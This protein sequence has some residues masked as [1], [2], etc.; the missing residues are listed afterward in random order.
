[1]WSRFLRGA[2]RRRAP[3]PEHSTHA[4][5][6]GRRHAQASRSDKASRS[7]TQRLDGCRATPHR[8]VRLDQW[9]SHPSSSR[10]RAHFIADCPPVG[11]WDLERGRC[12]STGATDRR[13]GHR[14]RDGPLVR[15]RPTMDCRNTF[16]DAGGDSRIRARTQRPLPAGIPRPLCRRRSQR[17]DDGDRRIR[18]QSLSVRPGTIRSLCGPRRPSLSA[19]PLSCL[20]P[21]RVD[22][23]GSRS[24]LLR[25][26]SRI[27]Y[28]SGR[29]QPRGCGL[30]CRLEVLAVAVR[31][32][33]VV[34]PYR[35][36]QLALPR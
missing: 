36:R 14:L 16:H 2:S 19:R 15:G 1:M 32:T 9:S 30:G 24:S 33:T 21:R 3:I 27:C 18:T 20:P 17:Y 26:P 34:S 35:P 13:R 10:N 11:L 4:S 5:L 7:V 6:G 23:G 31:F 12:P 22:S 25:H 8:S 28:G 29:G